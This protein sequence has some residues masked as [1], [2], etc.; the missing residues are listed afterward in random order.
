MADQKFDD[1][2]R[3]KVIQEIEQS[4]GI[5]LKRIG[6]FKKYLNGSDGNKYCVVGGYGGWHGLPGKVLEP[7][8]SREADRI[9][10]VARILKDRVELF[11]ASM[12]PLIKYKSELTKASK[13]EYQFD[14]KFLDSS[15]DRIFLRQQIPGY[16]LERF[17]FYK[18]NRLQSD[19]IEYLETASQKELKETILPKINA[20]LMRKGQKYKNG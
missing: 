9:L 6:N 19:L 2:D 15:R 16:F 12:K 18:Y 1:K 20:I 11:R 5:R 10:V 4:L 13:G 7:I 17:H 3:K 8:S 14:L